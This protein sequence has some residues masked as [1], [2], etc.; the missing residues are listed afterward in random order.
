[1]ENNQIT[2]LRTLGLSELYEKA[3][4]QRPLTILEWAIAKAIYVDFNKLFAQL[5]A[6]NMTINA[7]KRKLE[8]I[9]GVNI[10]YSN[11]EL[12][13]VEYSIEDRAT[14]HVVITVSTREDTGKL[15]VCSEF[16]VAISCQDYEYECLDMDMVQNIIATE[17]DALKD[18][19]DDI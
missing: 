8:H 5:G 13:V 11:D 18:I 12:I 4:T 7:L 3:N 1:M 10:R 6:T 17:D 9:N 2:L 15:Y 16:D 19:H 14:E